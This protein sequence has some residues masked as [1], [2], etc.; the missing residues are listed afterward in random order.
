MNGKSQMQ[1]GKN[2]ILLKEINANRFF[3]LKLS[4]AGNM[5]KPLRRLWDRMEP[6]GTV[7]WTNYL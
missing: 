3:F 4:L 7:A 2:L 6:W 5:E 1:G